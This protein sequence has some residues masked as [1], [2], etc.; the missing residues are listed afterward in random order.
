MLPILKHPDPSK[1]FIVEL[2]A[3]ERRVGAILLQR[4]GEKP[5]LQP[6]VYFPENSLPLNEIGKWELLTM[7]LALKEWRHW[8]EGAHNPFLIFTDH[9]TT[10]W[11]QQ[12]S[13]PAKRDGSASPGLI[14]AFC[15]GL[16]T[17]MS[18]WT[19]SPICTLLL[20]ENNVKKISSHESCIVG[21]LPWY[22]DQEIACANRLQ[23]PRAC[24]NWKTSVL[25]GLREILVT[26]ADTAPATALPGIRKPYQLLK[27][28][29]WWPNMLADIYK[30]TSSGTTCTQAKVPCT[31]GSM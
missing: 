31:Q 16:A 13:T 5:K 9:K 18:R 14:L 1:P 3:S 6:V 25:P 4:F 26:W 24:P 17:R 22:L 27:S 2:D 15:T 12:D 29:Y 30:I 28:K 7:K 21:A 20:P 8:L 11:P 23:N 10:H 19:Y